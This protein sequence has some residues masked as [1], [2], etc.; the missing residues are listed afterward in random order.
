M[1]EPAI[2]KQDWDRI[3]E[4]NGYVGPGF[5][6]SLSS[7]GRAAYYLHNQPFGFTRDMLR[8]IQRMQ[9]R[10]GSPDAHLIAA[11]C[12]RIEALLPPEIDAVTIDPSV[13]AFRDQRGPHLYE[14]T[15]NGNVRRVD[16]D[17]LPPE[18]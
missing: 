17:E 9:V 18:E 4:T 10:D 16:V 13:D 7:H 12:A 2:H 14:H 5:V 6:S 1:I 11:A 15:G 8:A 3:H